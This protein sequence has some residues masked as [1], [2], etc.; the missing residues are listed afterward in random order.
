MKEQYLIDYY[1]KFNEDK[2]L[3]RRHGIVEYQTTMFYLKKYLKKYKNPEILDL[4]AGT[5]A[6]SIPLS[7]LGYSV[8]ALELVKHNLMTLKK[9]NKNIRAL[10][11]NAL[12]LSKFE[13]ESFDIILI[14]GP[15]YHLMNEE[16]KI[17]CLEE[18]KRVLKEN[19]TI[20]I[21]YYMNEYGII[22]QG[23]KNQLIKEAIK[24]GQIDNEF[25]IISKEED[26]F[27]FVRIEDIKRYSKKVELKRLEMI[28]QDGPSDYLRSSLNSMDKETFSLFL[29][30][31]LKTC[32]R[33]DLL[34]ASSHIL[35][36]LKK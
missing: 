21:S 32:N 36:I 13:K 30:Y 22:T 4:G 14:F 34:G 15:M 11:G 23:F 24:K 20:F 1:N 3:T 5:G 25:H 8:T 27:S 19:G 26:L 35:D 6:Y 31:H 16:E 9:K 10:Q 2:R 17:K 33:K 12:N 29:E 7:E 18:A 28:A